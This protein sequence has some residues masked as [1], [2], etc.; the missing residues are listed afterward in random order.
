MTFLGSTSTGGACPTLY[1][2]GDGRIVVQGALL[3][4]PALIRQARDF[5]PGEVFVVV[6]A[7]LGRFW[8]AD[9]A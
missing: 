4:D 2:L 7:D 6:P 8:P 1:R 5:L 3:E 9:D